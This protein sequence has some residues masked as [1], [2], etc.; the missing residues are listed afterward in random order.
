MI[1][2]YTYY[3]NCLLSKK[4]ADPLPLSLP[5]PDD[6][7][8]FWIFVFQRV[9]EVHFQNMLEK[10]Y[11]WWSWPPYFLRAFKNESE[12]QT[13]NNKIKV[14]VN[15]QQQHAHHPLIKHIMIFEPIF[16][17]LSRIFVWGC[18]LN[19]LSKPMLRAC[20]ISCLLTF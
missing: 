16:F 9:Y 13:I 6:I 18:P 7:Y 8:L 17:W 19:P 15:K 2:Q 5:L 1:P 14:I 11:I 4:G 12:N 10:I 3:W 20:K